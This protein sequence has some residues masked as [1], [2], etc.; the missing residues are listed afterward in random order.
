MLSLSAG[1][2]VLRACQKDDGGQNLR[3][4]YMVL[5]HDTRVHILEMVDPEVC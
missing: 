2:A 1:P 4:I 3:A 5:P